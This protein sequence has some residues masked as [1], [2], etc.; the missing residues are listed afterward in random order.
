MPARARVFPFC[1]P[2]AEGGVERAVLYTCRSRPAM[3]PGGERERRVPFRRENTPRRGALRAFNQ[4]ETFSL[5]LSVL[6]YIRE[7]NVAYGIYGL[8]I[9]RINRLGEDGELL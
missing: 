4:G 9:N 1:D 3:T 5:R 6:V 8:L 2:R 7:A